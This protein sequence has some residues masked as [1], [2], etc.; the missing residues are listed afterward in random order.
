MS[1]SVEKLASDFAAEGRKCS[2][3]ERAVALAEPN[4]EAAWC[5]DC[6]VSGFQWQCT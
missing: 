2:A 5:D 6:Q 3:Y 4:A 1:D